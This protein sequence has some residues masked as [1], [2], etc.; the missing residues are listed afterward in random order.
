MTEDNGKPAKKKMNK[1]TLILYICGIWL[2]VCGVVSLFFWHNLVYFFVFGFTGLLCCISGAE[3]SGKD[4]EKEQAAKDEEKR[5]RARQ[6][7]LYNK[8]NAKK[9]RKK[10]S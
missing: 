10:K 4:K 9:N 1:W 6:N 5:A 8:E 2:I 3:T 7:D